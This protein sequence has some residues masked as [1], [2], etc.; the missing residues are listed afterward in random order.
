MNNEATTGPIALDELI[1]NAYLS[2]TTN[3]DPTVPEPCTQHSLDD[4]AGQFG[5]PE[6]SPAQPVPNARVPPQQPQT[7]EPPKAP[8]TAPAAAQ[9]K[10]S[11]KTTGLEEDQP[12][13][14]SSVPSLPPSKIPDRQ[15][16]NPKYK[17]FPHKFYSLYPITTQTNVADFETHRV[18]IARTQPALYA[19]FIDMLNQTLLHNLGP[20]HLKAKWAELHG[21][22]EP[23]DDLFD[24][25]AHHP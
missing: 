3:Q 18:Y 8:A 13:D 2:S 15:F 17:H 10:A 25:G 5:T 11:L 23:P 7:K 16:Y 21:F 19:V 4:I 6:P 14:A 24:E 1:N 12:D 22:E 20:D 9:P